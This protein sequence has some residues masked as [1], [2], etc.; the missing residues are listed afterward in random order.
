MRN[1]FTSNTF[2]DLE[3]CSSETICLPKT[4]LKRL[5][6]IG[7]GFAGLELVKKLKN[8]KIQIVL[9]DKNNFHQFQPL[10]YQVATSGLEPDSIAFPLRKQLAGYKNVN[11][12]LTEVLQIK[13]EENTIYT[14]KGIITYDYLVLATGTAT[15]FFGLKSVQKN[16]LG[17]KDIRDSLNIRHMMLQNLEQATITC[18]EQEKKALTNFVIVGGGPAGI[19][20]A[21]ALAEFCKYIIPKDYPEF[22]ASIMKI[23]LIEASNKILGVMSNKASSQS[24]K[25]LTD[26]N[27]NVLVNE[28]VIDYDGTLVKT[29]SGKEIN[30]KNL[31]WTAGVKGLFPDGLDNKDNIVRGNRLKTNENLKVI[32]FDNIYAIGDVSAMITEKT[33]KG[34]PQVAQPAIQQGKYLAENFLKIINNKPLKPFKYIDKGSLA[35]VGKRR[36]VADL[37]K[38]KFTGYFAWLL[39]SF[40]HLMSIS[41]FK[42]KLLVGLNWTISYFSYDKS[43]RLIIRKFKNN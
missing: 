13:P 36:A 19:E 28:A 10:L 4:T 14:T 29:K 9:I 39:W 8:N 27:V 42:N 12:R 34:H 15:N 38:L 11:F 26:L 37:G 40:V 33:P 1:N 25:Y 21:G 3:C 32:G 16:G 17:L 41:G 5:V 2:K 20:M 18:N 43:N 7:G 24:L 6:V 23:Y 31:I 35:T 22:S 30:A